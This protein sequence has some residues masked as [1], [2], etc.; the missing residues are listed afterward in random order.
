MGIRHIILRKKY[1]KDFNCKFF[2]IKITLLEL[3]DCTFILFQK[4]ISIWLIKI[5]IYK[6]SK[7]LKKYIF[8]IYNI[9]KIIF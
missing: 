9:I 7:V 3:L 8:L 4:K 2:D 6:N 1:C 5:T